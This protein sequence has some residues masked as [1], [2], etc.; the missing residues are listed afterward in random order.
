M[1]A[2]SARAD[3]SSRPASPA[4]FRLGIGA[5]VSRK[6]AGVGVFWVGNGPT[7][8]T[9]GAPI[10]VGRGFTRLNPDSRKV[11]KEGRLMGPEW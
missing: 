5:R 4:Y 11:D 6:D 3:R 10:E 2:C 1:I 8:A 9:D 7:A